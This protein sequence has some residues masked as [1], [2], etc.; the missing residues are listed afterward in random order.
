MYNYYDFNHTKLSCKILMKYK[1]NLPTNRLLNLSILRS[2][3]IKIDIFFL[4][5]NDNMSLFSNK[6]VKWLLEIRFV[7]TRSRNLQRTLL[8]PPKLIQ[9]SAWYLILMKKRK[10][11]YFALNI[12]A[13]DFSDLYWY[14]IYLIQYPYDFSNLFLLYF[15]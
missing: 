4:L 13:N 12:I 8:P 10:G 7:E 15:C 6:S 1:Q 3:P 14:D 11:N 5:I 2:L 9:N